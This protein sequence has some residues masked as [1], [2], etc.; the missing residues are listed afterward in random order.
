MNDTV[1]AGCFTCGHIE[2][3]SRPLSEADHWYRCECCKDPIA[4]DMFESYERA[5][6]AI[7]DQADFRESEGRPRFP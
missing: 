3:R 6:D 5:A 2:P 7:E 1:Y 4:P